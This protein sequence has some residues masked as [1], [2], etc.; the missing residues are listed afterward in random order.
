[1]NAVAINLNLN[2]SIAG[3]EDLPGVLEAV[4]VAFGVSGPAA[5]PPPAVFPPVDPIGG[6]A[7]RK[8]AEDNLRRLKDRDIPDQGWG[9]VKDLPGAIAQLPVETR[10]VVMRAVDNG[11]HVTRE[12]T[13]KVL[14][15]SADKTLKGFTRPVNRLMEGLKDRG[16]VTGTAEPLLLP[17]YT[18]GG[19]FAEAAQGFKVPVQVVHLLKQGN[20]A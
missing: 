13:Y 1:M 14:G 10:K 2:L 7:Y 8:I 20:D 19:A 6:A 3:L 16:E 5:S 12:E 9:N 4:K 11:G 18:D 17:I 15:R